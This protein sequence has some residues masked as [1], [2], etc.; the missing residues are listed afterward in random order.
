MGDGERLDVRHHRRPAQLARPGQG[1]EVGH[2]AALHQEQPEEPHE[3][4]AVAHPEQL[5]DVPGVEAVDPL[6]EEGR[7]LVPGEQRLRQPS[8]EEAPIQVLDPELL[9]AFA[10]EDGR[11]VDRRL[12]PGE[13][14]AELPRGRQG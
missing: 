10:P 12:P 6:G 9:A 3:A 4:D 1:A 5:L 7:V 11:E 8:V 14:V 2:A 13:A